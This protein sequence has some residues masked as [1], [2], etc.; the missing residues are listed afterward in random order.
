MMTAQGGRER[1]GERR[2]SSGGEEGG[3]K[4]TSMG[5]TWILMTVVRMIWTIRICQ[6]Y[7]M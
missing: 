7:E 3:G 1:E 4:G 2:G 5:E 6:K